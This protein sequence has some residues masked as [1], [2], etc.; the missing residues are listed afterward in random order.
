MRHH[1]LRFLALFL[2]ALG[3][4]LATKSWALHALEPG[5]TLE[6]I[7]PLLPLTLSFN[8]GAA[9]SLHFGDHS[10][11]AF[12]LFSIIA[13][14]GLLIYYHR[15][16]ASARLRA[17]VLPLIAA[18]AL[19]NLIDR[20]RWDLGVVDFLGPYDLG[21]MQWPIFNVADICISCGAILLSIALWLEERRATI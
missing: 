15:T 16:P 11:L 19:G 9:F 3:A 8:R 1:W 4:D 21:F 20:I 12:I 14:L 5:R 13:M 10:R 6:P 2:P 18:G 17:I 7:G